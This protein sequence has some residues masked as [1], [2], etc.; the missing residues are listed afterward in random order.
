MIAEPRIAML[1]FAHYHANF[2]TEAFLADPQAKVICIWDDDATR[3]K[4]AATRFGVAFEPDLS[5]ALA[6]CDAVAICS[7]TIAHQDLTRAACA[8]GRAI[9]CEK[10]TARTVAEVDA[11]AAAVAEA[12]VLFMQSFPKR[13]DPA[14]HALKALMDK[15]RLGRVHLVRIRHGHFYGLEPDFRQRWYVDKTKGGGGALLDEGVHGADLLHWFFGL[16]STVTAETTSPVAGLSVDETATAVFRYADGMMAE[17]TASFLLPAADT[18]IEIYG[19]KATA[20]LS[21]VDLASR[22][23]TSDGF[24]RVSD[25]VTGSKRWEV[26]DITPQFKLGQFHHQNAIGFLRCLRTNV[27]PPAGIAAGR[28]ALLMIEAAYRAARTGTRQSVTPNSGIES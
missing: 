3:G 25:D 23:I 1:S 11:M 20:L 9:L 15:G 17:L 26:I 7:E 18:S 28:A 4:E 6:G 13:F 2:W 22:D 27:A 8:A 24:L 21:G 12:G 10:P 14:S 19:T 5:A 16:P